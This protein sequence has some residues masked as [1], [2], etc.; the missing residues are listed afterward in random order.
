MGIAA[1][2]VI[3]AYVEY[4]ALRDENSD[5]TISEIINDTAKAQPLTMVAIGAC[6]AHFAGGWDSAQRASGKYPLLPLATGAIVGLCHW[7]LKGLVRK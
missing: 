7:P 3:L 1:A 2:G 5:D 4:R 6:A